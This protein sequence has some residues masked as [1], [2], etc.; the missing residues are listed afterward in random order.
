MLLQLPSDVLPVLLAT[1]SGAELAVLATVGRVLR[2]VLADP[3][4]WSAA[5]VAHAAEHAPG[6]GER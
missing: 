3:Q 6:H 5:F 4:A 2:G 1:C